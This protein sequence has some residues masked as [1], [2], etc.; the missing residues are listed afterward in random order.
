[1]KAKALVFF[2]FILSGSLVLAYDAEKTLTLS[3]EGI[4][5]LKVDSGSG[6]LSIIGREDL[7]SIEVEAKIHIKGVREGDIDEFI[8]D[9][10]KLSLRKV[11]DSAVLVAKFENRNLFRIAREAW[12]DLAVSVPTSLALDLDDGSGDTEVKNIA[13][14]VRID[15][16]SGALELKAISGGVRIDDGSGSLYVDDVDGDLIVDDSSGEIRIRNVTGNVEVDDSSGDMVILHVGGKV[17]VS[18][19][20]G[21]IEIDDVGGDVLLRRSGSGGL[22]V[23]NV[24]G[25]VVKKA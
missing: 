15:D 12:I 23:T 7:A 24:K 25:R 8:R 3:A 4:M 17:T 19:G 14:P 16:G 18:D 6:A 13:A 20:S 21:S 5:Q 9:H 11:G 10:M 2:L 22:D 1:M